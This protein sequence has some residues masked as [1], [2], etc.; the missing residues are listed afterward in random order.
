LPTV[1]PLDFPTP[2]GLPSQ[3]PRTNAVRCCDPNSL[4][5][6]AQSA[7]LIVRAWVLRINPPF[8]NTPD[9]KPPAGNLQL[10]DVRSPAELQVREI[11]KGPT[12]LTEVVVLLNGACF[13]AT[14]C[15]GPRDQYLW[16]DVVGY[17]VILFLSR[18]EG[19]SVEKRYADAFAESHT[20]VIDPD[21]TKDRVLYIY[22]SA[23]IYQAL[24]ILL[25]QI[26]SS[27]TTPH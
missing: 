13:T 26:H 9:G 22:G 6:S 10:A 23:P 8:W 21:P 3:L 17:D 20:Y 7:D 14:N 5:T 18:P 15:V 1:I 2:A 27:L 24:S 16:N 19:Q 12:G 25:A 11:Y 4:K